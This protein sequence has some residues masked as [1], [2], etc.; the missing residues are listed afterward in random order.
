MD[1]SAKTFSATEY[2]TSAYEAIDDALGALQKWNQSQNNACR[3]SSSSHSQ[4][5]SDDSVCSCG[6]CKSPIVVRVVGISCFAMS[7]VG[8]GAD[9]EAVT[10]VYSY[11]DARNQA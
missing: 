3:H 9:G 4:R 11:A 1:A 2:L 6:N 8:V 10:P 5:S 7:L